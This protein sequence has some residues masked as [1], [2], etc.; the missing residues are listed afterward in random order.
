MRSVE[1]EH[2]HAGAIFACDIMHPARGRATRSGGLGRAATVRGLRTGFRCRMR[3]GRLSLHVLECA[4]R[5]IDSPKIVDY[6]QLL[7]IRSSSAAGW[8]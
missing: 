4:F 8:G 5:V 6:V 3:F 1:P 2:Y 7:A